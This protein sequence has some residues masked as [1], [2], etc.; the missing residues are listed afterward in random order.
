VTYTCS[1]LPAAWKVAVD[2]FALADGLMASAA[3]K[4][5]VAARDARPVAERLLTWVPSNIPV[6]LP[7]FGHA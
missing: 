5:I 3:L 6:H 2:W 1:T 7:M 4:T